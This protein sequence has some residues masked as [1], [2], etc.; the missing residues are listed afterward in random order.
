MPEIANQSVPDKS[1]H[2]K[3]THG[4]NFVI[5]GK[6]RSRATWDPDRVTESQPVDV[7]SSATFYFIEAVTV[8][9]ESSN[10]R[11]SVVTIPH[12]ALHRFTRGR[13]GDKI[14][15]IWSRGVWAI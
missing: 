2:D 9:A 10:V 12:S 15:Q 11:Y 8:G 3:N 4:K 13:I 7:Y 6:R 5:P 14:Y 1:I